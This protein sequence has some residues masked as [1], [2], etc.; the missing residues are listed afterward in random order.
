MLV[1]ENVYLEHVGVRGMRWG[2]RKNRP[3]TQNHQAKLKS[4]KKAAIGTGV[5]LGSAALIAGIAV[6]AHR[7][8]QTLKLKG[9]MSLTE[10]F[11]TDSWKQA[12]NEGAMWLK[13][14]KWNY[15][16]PLDKFNSA[17]KDLLRRHGVLTIP[18][19]TPRQL[20][21]Q[22]LKFVKNNMKSIKALRG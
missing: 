22:D 13:N 20:S 14:G 4:V 12:G 5:A 7:A 15:G 11:K 8:S 21:S 2:Q 1:D 19:A 17:Q 3:E 10:A 9:N 16:L 6:G 18:T